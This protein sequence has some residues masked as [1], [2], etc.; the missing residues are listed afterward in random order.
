MASVA[1][2]LANH[3]TR[4]VT[5]PM[6]HGAALGALLKDVTHEE[7]AA[8]P[9]A[10]AHTIWELVLHIT[11]W[12]GIARARIRGERTADATGAEDWPPVGPT[13]AAEWQ[14]AL[15]R[16]R[17]GHRALATDVRRLDDEAI[18]AKV[19]G[20][21]YTVSNLLHGVIEHGTYHG[22]QIA[23]LMRALQPA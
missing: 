1:A 8:R 9:I 18:E 17:Q 15:E 14:A 13:G 2:H 5:G 16:L 6:W 10:G 22:G 12:T 7:A 3:I 20:L 19:R 21:D 23:L 11:A 4:T